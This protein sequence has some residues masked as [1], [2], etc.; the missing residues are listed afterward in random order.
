MS[1]KKRRSQSA[2]GD[3]QA[4]GGI[5]GWVLLIYFGSGMASLIDEVVWTRLLKLTLGNTVYASSI[6][7]SM[8][9]GGL[10]LG[11]YIMS[12][13]ADRI[14]RPLRL[15]AALELCATISA[16]SVPVTL[17]IA[18]AGYRLLYLRWR[19][20]P[21][22]LLLLQILVSALIVL[23]PAM[24]MGST[25]PLLARFVTEMRQQVGRLVGRLYALN[26]LGAALGCF[27]AGFI[28]I[29]L[30]GVLGTLLAAA[31][32]NLAAAAAGWALSRSR[33][34]GLPDKAED[35]RE[36]PGGGLPGLAPV[37]QRGSWLL[38]LS[39][40]SSGLISIGYELVWMRAI[41][42][43]IGSYTYVFSAVLTIYLL[44]NFVGAA[45]GSR[46]AARVAKPETAFGFSLIALGLFGL[47]LGPWLVVWLVETG[48]D[49]ARSLF[50]QSVHAPVVS[51]LVL[52]LFYS[53]LLFLLPSIAMGIGFPL[54]LQAWSRSRAGVGA[55]T[56]VVYAINTI[57]AVL[58]GLLAGF[59]LIPGLG[60]QLSGIVLGLVAVWLGTLLVV[61][62]S[63]PARP[64]V[65]MV[66]LG[67]GAGLTLAALLVPG[68]LFRRRIVSTPGAE[69]V[70]VIE[71][72]TTTVA[73]KRS[74]ANGL[75]LSSDGV[76]VAGDGR[77]R[78]AQKMLGHLAML[79]HCDARDVL[80]VGFGGGETT[81]CLATHRPDFI[82]CVEIAPEVTKAALDYFHHINL[83]PE[84][85]QYV[86]MT[87]MDAKNFLHITDEQYD[88]I[89]NDADIPSYSGSAPLFGREHFQC[90]R[91]HLKPGG[92]VVSKLHLA[93]VPVSSFNSILGTFM[94]VFP[95]VTM[96]FPT[97]KPVSFFYMVGSVE[98]QRFSPRCI[99][100]ILRR[101]AVQVSTAYMHWQSS[102]D[103]AMCYIGDEKSLRSHLKAYTSNSDY[104]P[105]VEFNLDQRGS[106]MLEDG[107]DRFVQGV[108]RPSLGDHIDW[109][110][111]GPGERA[112]WLAGYDRYYRAG[113]HILKMAGEDNPFNLLRDVLN[114]LAILP[115]HAVLR[116][117][118]EKSLAAFGSGIAAGNARVILGQID[119]IVQEFPQSGIPWMIK[120]LAQQSIGDASGAASSAR[121]ALDLAQS[122][123]DQWLVQRIERDLPS[124]DAG[125]GP[126]R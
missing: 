107:L 90:A 54:A 112:D 59:V 33:E 88:V 105:F 50:G 117:Q 11:A 6:V 114:G 89:I 28:L 45:T 2:A 72:P 66:G 30:L 68:D 87:H 7:V 10:A 91:G 47:A 24:I 49:L 3:A 120:A 126:S 53:A 109:G 119:T 122:A 35:A 96:W 8:F 17:R 64:Y 15:Y 69:T 77:L 79:L 103:L 71:G 123:G 55:T 113:T 65:R 44:G 29:R 81:A 23:V 94:E 27:L 106:A 56:G 85:D 4:A 121:S 60:I 98:E 111:M 43:P 19:P 31:A 20:S 58:G 73:V 32:V 100:A 16:I 74:P 92:L 95:H 67:L 5:T 51:A 13:H 93:G 21:E 57:G 84:L 48:P 63:Q 108:R 86:H 124:L 115:D 38:P 83:G 116:E 82:R 26:T 46:L 70:A 62:F 104:A 125:P 22:G 118:E 80:S 40:F 76:D 99:D 18:D 101:S 102:L 34:H 61:V 14:R 41:V 42:I 25:L 12:R 1:D 39:F 97:T 75:T 78:S 37:P 110:N 52:P 36:S 9:M